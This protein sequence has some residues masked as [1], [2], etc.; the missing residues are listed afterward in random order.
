PHV[1]RTLSYD[2]LHDFAPVT[3]VCTVPFLLVVGPLVPPQVATLAHFIAWCRAHRA[4]AS[5]GS[6]GAGTLP[7]FL[8]AALAREAGFDFVRAPYRGGAQAIQALVA[9][10]LASAL[11]SAA[12]VLAHVQSG[13]L[14]ALACTAAQPSAALPAVPTMRAAGYPG[15]EGVVWLGI[16]A[17]AAT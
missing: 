11:L 16:L 5:Y 8:G 17:P 6:P 3:T 4:L 10:Q 12:A 15:L 13:R 7:H 9:G 14:R 1:Y 2:P